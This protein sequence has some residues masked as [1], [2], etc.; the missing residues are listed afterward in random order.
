MKKAL[1]LILT[2]CLSQLMMAVEKD[3]SIQVAGKSRSF[4]L[5][6]PS[7][8]KDNCPLV[9]SLHGA[10]GSSN[11][12]SPFGTDV[13]DQAGCIVVYPQGLPTAFPVGFGGSANG[14]T[15]TGEENF[16]T[17]FL[18]AVID[19]VAKSYKIDRKR[20]YCCGFSNG[21]MMTYAMSC[22]CSDV[23]AAFASISGYQLNEFHLRL[24]GKRPVPF[25][26]IHGK[27]DDFVLY[28]LMPKIVCQMVTRNGANPVPVKTVKSGKYTKSVYEAQEGGFPYVYY[29]MDGMGH[30]PYTGNTE[31][32]NS[33]KT[34][35]NFFKQYTLDSPCDTTL[36]WRA[37]VE[38]EGFVPKDYG[39]TMNSSTY[40][41]YFGDTPQASGNN[42][43]HN[44]YR[45]LQFVNGQY[46]LCFRTKGEAGKTVTVKLQKL[47]V[48]GTKGI[49]LEATANVGEDVVLPFEVKD[50]WGEYRLTITHTKDDGTTPGNLAIHALTAEEIATGITST[51]LNAPLDLGRFACKECLMHNEQGSGVYNLQGQRLSKPGKGINIVNGK[52]VVMK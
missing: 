52:V 2:L 9:V 15:A 8:A 33:G 25:L 38:T 24:T 22:A 27:A 6:V 35:W 47:P 7:S 30:S 34:M 42:D 11:D 44:V 43:K 13:A 5:Y 23:F 16:D 26:H 41:F 37:N 21:G 31:E 29:E 17:E 45:T 1:L 39:F 12:K 3:V 32:G 36:K 50:G 10:G 51:M 49:I 18:L 20:L 28:E 14:W 40:A 46:K 4:K 19:E 48:S